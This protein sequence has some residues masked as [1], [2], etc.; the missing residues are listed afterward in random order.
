MN[1]NRVF[2]PLVL[3]GSALL[4]LLCFHR[5][6]EY[7]FTDKDSLMH[8]TEARVDDLADVR[9]LLSKP[10]TGGRA[11]R[12]AN[13]YRP[14]VMLMYAGL[15]G[16]FGWNPLGYHA[17]DLGLH[18]LNGWLLALFATACARRT[19]KR[20]PRRFGLLCG[21]IF[22]IHP[23]G[24][25]TVPAIARNGD[26]LMTSLFLTA[27]LALDRSQPQ[28]S[29][30]ARS[31]FS[32]AAYAA[33]FYGLFALTLG[34]KEPGI[35][36]LCAAFLSLAWLPRDRVSGRGLLHTGLWIAPCLAIA[37]TYLVIRSRVLGEML[38]G[39]DVEF[40]LPTM[41]RW[42]ANL[43]PLDLTVPGFV[44]PIRTALA[45]LGVEGPGQSAVPAALVATALCGWMGLVWMASPRGFPSRRASFAEFGRQLADLALS[46]TGRLIGFAVA[47]IA[48]HAA[49][50]AVT[51][52]YD[53]R[54]LYTTV[55]FFSFLPA[56]AV[57]W[58]L[59]TRREGRFARSLP[60]LL[61]LVG[62][63]I[64]F[65]AQ[66]PL[67][68]RYDEWRSSGEVARLLTEGIRKRWEMLPNHASVVIFNMP[69]GFSTDPMRRVM[70]ADR[71]STHALAP[72]ALKAWLEDQF[73]HKQ[74]SLAAAGYT[75]Y[76]EPIREFRHGA[77]F[78]EHWLL[79]RTP[80]GITDRDSVL[81]DRPQFRLVTTGHH[82][83]RLAYG[84]RPIPPALYV[85][86]VDGRHPVLVAASRI[87]GRPE[88][89]S[90]D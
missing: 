23:L 68:H 77:N 54:L 37:A 12:D 81:E 78:V 1:R 74:I 44:E 9:A 47:I 35:L 51:E 64:V 22:S 33:A 28:P 4:T 88:P 20:R 69:S 6:L 32:L 17:F 5:V 26:L 29:G 52:V 53:R 83:V 76:I 36:L 7:G 34:A 49:L 15:R 90:D 11:P 38:G 14:T 2:W 80:R 8:V 82:R 50:F 63:G 89:E 41:I 75:R 59:E 21:L 10:L 55:A 39:Y 65:L 30:S 61:V 66:S 24:V 72:N 84:R 27:L 60:G 3:L 71:S 67:V 56:L 40:S 87:P 19:G 62:S 48:A 85:L 57:H 79:F 25:E 16:A 31:R 13:F 46:A 58:A 18:A 70:F 45:P 42:V 86:V 43:M 73:P